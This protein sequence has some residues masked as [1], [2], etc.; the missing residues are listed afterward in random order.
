M[1]RGTA[2]KKNKLKFH[3][4]KLHY[5]S[6]QKNYFTLI[7]KFQKFQKFAQNYS[8]AHNII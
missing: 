2:L 8:K 3:F 1:K 7:Q 6:Y 4:R 5:K